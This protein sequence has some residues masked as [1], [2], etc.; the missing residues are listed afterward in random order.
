M[1]IYDEKGLILCQ[2]CG[3]GLNQL[4]YNHL[5]FHNMTVTEYIQ[6]YKD[7][8]T[9]SK[10]YSAKQRLKNVKLF[11]GNNNSDIIK[12]E[13]IEE[14]IKPKQEIMI[15]DCLGDFNL[16]KIPVVTKE[17]TESVTNFIDEVKEF[18]KEKTNTKFPDPNNII[19]KDK[20]KI[21][22]FL[23]FYFYDLKNSFYIEKTSLSGHLEYRLITD[24]CIPSLKLNIE[25]PNTFWHNQDVP[26][27]SRDVILKKD[28]WR[29]INISGSKPSITQIKESLKKYNLI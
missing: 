9:V 17:F 10:A 7:Y 29:I 25:F 5:K 28:G 22:D 12:E 26:K 14:E 3:K 15:E 23:L 20:L 18:S 19:H 27:H 21:L 16:D 13:I 1:E 24:I 8:P 2:E 11:E 6:K 4:T